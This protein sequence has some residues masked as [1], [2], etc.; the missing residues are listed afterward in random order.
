MYKVYYIIGNTHF[1]EECKRIYLKTE[2]GL[3]NVLTKD[4][5]YKLIDL[6]TVSY[7]EI[8]K[9]KENDKS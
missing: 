2:L 3:L 9:E 6:N 5:N 8:I 1:T 7:F 4:N